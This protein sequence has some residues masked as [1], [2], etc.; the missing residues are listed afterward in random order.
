MLDL[1][2]SRDT[3]RRVDPAQHWVHRIGP[4]V[5]DVRDAPFDAWFHARARRQKRRP[6]QGLKRTRSPLAKRNSIFL[7]FTVLK[8]GSE[9]ASISTISS[10]ANSASAVR[11]SISGIFASFASAMVAISPLATRVYGARTHSGN[12]P[13]PQNHSVLAGIIPRCT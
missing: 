5:G 9:V 10:A 13:A 1:R 6:C 3:T 2:W 8:F 12:L 7:Y 4:V 11:G